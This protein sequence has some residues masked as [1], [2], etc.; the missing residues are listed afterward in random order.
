MDETRTPPGRQRPA[1]SYGPA[2]DATRDARIIEAALDLLAEQG[3]ADLTM[4]EVAVRARVGKA[5]VYRRWASREDLVADALESLDFTVDRSTGPLRPTELRADLV[6]TLTSTSGCA[7][8]RGSRLAAVLLATTRSNPEVTS[9]LRK[10]YVAAQRIGIADCLRRAVARGEADRTR[11]ELLLEP[12]RLE[13]TA[14]IA[15]IMHQP[16]FEEPPL[17][18]RYVEHIVDQVLVPLATGTYAAP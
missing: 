8:A 11:V 16:L 13:V 9:A 15:L 4:G 5:T 17:D 18:T 1:A 12:G 7:G 14:A 2:R 10:R 6:H 3:Y